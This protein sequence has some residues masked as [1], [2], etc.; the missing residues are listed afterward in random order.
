MA[1]DAMALPRKSDAAATD[2]AAGD[3]RAGPL[4]QFSWAFFEFARNP[5]VSMVYIFVF[6]PYFANTVVGDPI[7]GQE[8]WSLINTIQALIVGASAPMGGAA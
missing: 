1:S 7:R 6:A 8:V 5:Y 2:N 3:T 4:G